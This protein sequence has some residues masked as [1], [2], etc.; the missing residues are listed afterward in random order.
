LVIEG[1]RLWFFGVSMDNFFDGE[2]S[3]WNNR[4][5][6]TVFGTSAFVV[7]IDMV[8]VGL[9]GLVPCLL[10]GS[11][12]MSL[13]LLGPRLLLSPFGCDMLLAI[14]G[15]NVFVVIL[16]VNGL[17][18]RI[19]IVGHVALSGAVSAVCTVMIAE[20]VAI[21]IFAFLALLFFWLAR[22]EIGN[23]EGTAASDAMATDVTFVVSFVVVFSCLGALFGYPRLS[24]DH[25]GL[26]ES[27]RVFP[28][29][30]SELALA[31]VIAF[32]QEGKTQKLLL[33]LTC[34]LSS[35]FFRV[36][37]IGTEAAGLGIASAV[38]SRIFEIGGLIAMTGC[39]RFSW[40]CCLVL[41][42]LVH[43][44]LRHVDHRV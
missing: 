8:G 30:R 9:L 34:A 5:F 33:L 7:V 21:A 3:V 12:W 20:C 6:S 35:Q 1:L 19:A 22:H 31:S 38:S 23:D 11:G 25:W 40:I 26:C 43:F 44:T 18:S 15:I 39:N 42:L 27:F 36:M 24:P 32:F 14:T 41:L 2:D 13:V 17:R 10:G 28:I 29:F 4:L 37:P 16:T